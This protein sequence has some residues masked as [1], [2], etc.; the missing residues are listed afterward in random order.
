MRRKS[1]SSSSQEQ[2]VRMRMICIVKGTHGRNMYLWNVC[3][4]QER[5]SYLF[6]RFLC[7]NLCL[8]V[9]F[10]VRGSRNEAQFASSFRVPKKPSFEPP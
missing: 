9:S 6:A 1:K 3:Y 10:E 8:R 7:H 4:E 5:F 2:H